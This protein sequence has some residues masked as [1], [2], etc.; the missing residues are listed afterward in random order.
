MNKGA[1]L[2]CFN[3]NSKKK[4]KKKTSRNIGEIKKKNSYRLRMIAFFLLFTIVYVVMSEFNA[5]DLKAI[6]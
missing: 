1:E 4:L 3:F 2:S 6:P 5:I